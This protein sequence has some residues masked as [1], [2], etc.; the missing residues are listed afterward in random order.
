MKESSDSSP[1]LGARGLKGENIMVGMRNFG[2][3]AALCLSWLCAEH[4]AASEPDPIFSLQRQWWQWAGSI[5]LDVNPLIDATGKFCDVGQRGG[6][7]Y[8][9]SNFGGRTTRSCTVPKGVKLLVPIVVTF[10]YPEE[11]FDTDE[12]C[13]AYVN[14]VM[15]AYR[16]EDMTIRLDG[17]LQ[18]THDICE[19][20]AAPGDKVGNVGHCVVRR[21]PNRTLFT[22]VVGSAGFYASDPGV[23][24]ANSARGA[25]AVIDTANLAAGSHVLKIKAVGQPGAVIPFMSVTYKLT[26]ARPVN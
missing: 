18:P 15:N 21:R 11:G 26:I 8:L 17:R 23:Y 5:P 2:A 12:S 7:W 25:W 4:A 14:D 6:Y 19:I 22:F 10:C 1:Q 9:A 20:A 13:I 24:R 3:I 16:P